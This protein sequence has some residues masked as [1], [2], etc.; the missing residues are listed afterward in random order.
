MP[1]RPSS[2]L[3]EHAQKL[4]E[5]HERIMR[6]LAAA[7]KALRQKPKAAPRPKPAEERKVK[8]RNIAS[9]DL[10][11]P[12]DHLYRGGKAQTPRRTTRRRKTDA[13]LAQIKFLLLCL[14]L[15]ALVLFV[16]KNLPG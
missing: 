16:W 7:E 9:L 6:E 3:S 5:E 1:R 14:L 11:R 2:P 4:Q 10:P 15:A 13:R 8:I 12:Q